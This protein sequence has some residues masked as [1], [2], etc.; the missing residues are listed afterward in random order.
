VAPV[1]VAPTRCVGL[2]LVRLALVAV[3]VA[4]GRIISSATRSDDEVI[5]AKLWPVVWIDDLDVIPGGILGG[6]VALGIARA[7]PVEVVAYGGAV[8]AAVVVAGIRLDSTAS[9]R[10]PAPLRLGT[11]T[12][13]RTHTQ[14]IYLAR[15]KR[16]GVRDAARTGLN[17]RASSGTS[18]ICHSASFCPSQCSSQ[19]SVSIPTH[20]SEEMN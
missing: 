18:A 16:T 5:I 20:A 8:F 15:L 14:L 7:Q 1:A 10:R 4:A 12:H 6:Y 17:H 3:A 9:C 11:Y 2:A 13:A 19:C